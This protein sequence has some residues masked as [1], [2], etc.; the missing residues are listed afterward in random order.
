MQEQQKKLAAL[1]MELVVAQQE[2]FIS[3]NLTIEMQSVG[4][5]CQLVEYPS[6]YTLE[7]T[8]ATHLNKPRVYIGC[9]KSSEV[10]SKLIHK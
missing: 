1:E 2:D 6:F 9:M 7:A 8:L 4:D 10:F 3:K 5:G